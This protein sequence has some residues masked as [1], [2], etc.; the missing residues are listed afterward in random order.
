[1]QQQNQNLGIEYLIPA[2]H[3]NDVGGFM[4]TKKT[5]NKLTVSGG[6][7]YNNRKLISMPLEEGGNTK[8]ASFNKNFGNVSASIG[9]TYDITETVT[10]KLNVA[11]GFRAPNIAELSAN[12][13]HEGTIKYEYGNTE[14]KS[15]TS[16]ETD[17]GIDLYT[18]HITFS[19]SIFLNNIQHYIFSRKLNSVFGGDS[20]PVVANTEGFSAFK[21]FQTTAS[22]YG[23][24]IMLDIHPHPL[25][26]LHFQNTFSYVRAT[27][28]F[29]TDSTENLPNIPPARWLLELQANI[30]NAGPVIRNLYFNIGTDCTFKQDKVFSAYQT[31]MATPGYI[32][33][34]AGLGAN[35][36]NSKKQTLFGLFF[37]A[38]NLTDVAYQNHLSRLKYAPANLVTDRNGVFNMGRNF[39]IKLNVPLS[40]TL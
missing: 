37:S 25:D 36:V 23:A 21:Y 12:G 8:F 11:R 15:E 31:E 18:Q 10:A 16:L 19:G 1:M 27:S 6:A 30:K 29:K 40:F 20:I 22:L 2:Y 24:E 9:A 4:Y 28:G 33:L 38:N 5:F 13:V 39:S 3:F 32:L 7:R 34:N 14:L 35:I 17:A 26:W